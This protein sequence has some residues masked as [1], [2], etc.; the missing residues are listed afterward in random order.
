MALV[1]D[2]AELMM[3]PQP[4]HPQVALA[5]PLDAALRVTAI[6]R[7]GG[8][9]IAVTSRQPSRPLFKPTALMRSSTDRVETP[10]HRPPR[11]GLP[12]AGVEI[13]TIYG[14]DAAQSHA[15]P[16]ELSPQRCPAIG[17]ASGKTLALD[18]SRRYGL[19]HGIHMV[20][21]NHPDL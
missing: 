16:C 6:P 15:S 21:V 18:R 11:I 1:P 14:L 8:P 19:A 5:Q 17:T 10:R 2:W 20:A 4:S 9:R 3:A 12:L 13:T 7:C